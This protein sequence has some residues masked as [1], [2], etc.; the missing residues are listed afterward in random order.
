MNRKCSKGHFRTL[1]Q[2][3]M[4]SIIIENCREISSPL[5]KLSILGTISLFLDNNGSIHTVGFP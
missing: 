5:L 4:K 3:R 1:V 2:A